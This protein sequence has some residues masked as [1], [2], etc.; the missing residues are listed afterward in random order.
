MVSSGNLE[1]R[2]W[3]SAARLRSDARGRDGGVREEPAA[4]VVRWKPKTEVEGT[5]ILPSL[6]S[7]LHARDVVSF[8]L[9]TSRGR[10]V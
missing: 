6:T 10:G 2:G 1:R 4:G 8:P 9:R 3:V 7:R 5:S